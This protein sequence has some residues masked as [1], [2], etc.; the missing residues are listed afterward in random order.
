MTMNPEDFGLATAPVTFDEWLSSMTEMDRQ[1]VE[2]MA[3]AVEPDLWRKIDVYE[4]ASR[5]EGA[6]AKWFAAEVM[7]LRD[8]AIARQAPALF[9][10]RQWE[11][12]SGWVTVPRQMTA[13]M[14]AAVSGAEP[15]MTEWGGLSFAAGDFAAAV[16]AAPPA[17]GVRARP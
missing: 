17:P 12:N 3:R 7:K 4:L 1:A 10:I 14:Y 2:A 5:E 15:V 16:S 6:D 11:K 13:A 9:A 8:G